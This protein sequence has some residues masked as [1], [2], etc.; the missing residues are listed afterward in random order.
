MRPNDSPVSSVTRLGV[1][2]IRTGSPSRST[3]SS[4]GFSADARTRSISARAEVIGSPPAATMRSPASRPAL[5]AALP[6]ATRP[7]RGGPLYGTMPSRAMTSPVEV[8]GDDP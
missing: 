1:T 3:V 5:A 7:T 6:S 8:L 4:S 2:R